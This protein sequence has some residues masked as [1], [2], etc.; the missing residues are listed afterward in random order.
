MTHD[1]P[2]KY[3]AEVSFILEDSKFQVN[4]LHLIGVTKENGLRF[5][6]TSYPPIKEKLSSTIT[7]P[8]N[9]IEAAAIETLRN[10]A[11]DYVINR[12]KG[13]GDLTWFKTQVIVPI[14]ARESCLKCHDAKVGDLLGAFSY[15]TTEQSKLPPSSNP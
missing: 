14:I 6:D 7:R 8:L 12:P 13:D 9:H 11:Q 5:F 10:Q 3:W 4:E 2:K 15:E 1:P